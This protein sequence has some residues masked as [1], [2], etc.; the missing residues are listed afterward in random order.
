MRKVRTVVPWQ[1]PHEIAEFVHRRCAGLVE[2][3]MRQYPYRDVIKVLVLSCYTQGLADGVEVQRR[4][5]NSV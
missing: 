2:Y 4:Q 5:P 3:S 1:V